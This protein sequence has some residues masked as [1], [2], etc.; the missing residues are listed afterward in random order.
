M[1]RPAGRVIADASED[2]EGLSAE[3]EGRH[4]VSL[5]WGP[6]GGGRG[7]R[8]IAG[9]WH[10]GHGPCPHGGGTGMLPRSMKKMSTPVTET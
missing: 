10:C 9:A 4:D 2:R 7:L 8:T 1:D 6:M 5:G 3:S